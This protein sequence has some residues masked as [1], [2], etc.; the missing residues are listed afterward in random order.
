MAFGLRIYN[1]DPHGGPFEVGITDE[2]IQ[3][4]KL[5]LTW[6]KVTQLFKFIQLVKGGA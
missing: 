5:R 6:I 3:M 4:R 1:S 2:I